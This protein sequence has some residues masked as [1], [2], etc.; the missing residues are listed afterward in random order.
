LNITPIRTQG[1]RADDDGAFDA[2]LRDLDGAGERG[3]F[4]LVYQKQ[5]AP[6]G[7]RV[8]AVESLL[9]WEHPTLGPVDPGH[10]IPLAEQ[11]GLIR[12]ITRWVLGRAMEETKDL[13]GVSVCF[14]ASALEFAD[15][16]FADEIEAL[17]EARGFDPACLEIEVT[18]TAI[19]VDGEEVHRTMAR[20]HALGARIALDD[21]GVGYSSLNHLRLYPFDKLK[22][23]K[24]F[25]T[26]CSKGE[27]SATLIH[28][29][30]GLG[31]ALGMAVVAEGVE[32]QTQAAFLRDA[33]VCGLQGYLFGRP[34]PI[35][36]IRA[37][38]G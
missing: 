8:I 16:E 21:F 28:A 37:E 5:M 10:F 26:E 18:E 31:R 12:P 3:E 1:R 29:V 35:E 30:I 6:D 34:K 19:L 22:I 23:D 11:A 27:Q 24:A 14:N 33:G 36:E 32:T 17:V 15:P 38:L 7:R 25:V 13:K 2:L 4:S 9:R 20:L